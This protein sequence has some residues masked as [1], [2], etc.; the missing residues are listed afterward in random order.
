L[1]LLGLG[2]AG[3]GIGTLSGIVGA[4]LRAKGENRPSLGSHLLRHGWALVVAGAALG[5]ML[6]AWTKLMSGPLDL[7]S[8]A[9]PAVVFGPLAVLAALLLTVTLHLGLVSRGIREAARELWSRHG[10]PQLR[11]GIGWLAITGAALFDPLLLMW[12]DG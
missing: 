9:L 10:A 3:Y 5:G 1:C 4:W 2:V 7:L 6:I 12:A 11:F 8:S